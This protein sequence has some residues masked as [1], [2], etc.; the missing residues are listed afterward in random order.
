M[1]TPSHSNDWALP[2]RSQAAAASIQ[3]TGASSV[4]RRESLSGGGTED[5]PAFEPRRRRRHIHAH[6]ALTRP[7]LAEIGCDPAHVRSQGLCSERLSH[8]DGRLSHCASSTASSVLCTAR[9]TSPAPVSAL[10]SS[11]SISNQLH[12]VPSA[13]RSGRFPGEKTQSEASKSRVRAHHRSG[14]SLTMATL[15]RWWCSP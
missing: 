9:G 15:E 14:V 13:L 11:S 4:Q 8:C 1:I 3:T 10:V 12:S 2:Y 5:M 6:G 7:S